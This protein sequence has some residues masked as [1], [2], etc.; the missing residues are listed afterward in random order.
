M[1][2]VSIET[3]R[4]DNWKMLRFLVVGGW[5]TFFGWGLFSLLWIVWGTPENYVF[6]AI[7]SHFT[8]VTQAY[9]L[10]S[11]HVFFSEA[12]TVEQKFNEFIKFNLS[13]IGS[14]DIG[15]STLWF[16]VDRIGIH[17]I[18]AQGITLAIGS[19]ISFFAHDKFSF[20][21]RETTNQQ[22]DGGSNE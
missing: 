19:V 16:L 5:N 2:F 3:L 1:D 14:L 18:A 20:K 17:P 4:K 9:F 13:Y 21:K 8:A 11:R 7:G 15:I 6:L 10:Y 22:K 12:S